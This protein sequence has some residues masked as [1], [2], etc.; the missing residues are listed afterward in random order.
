MLRRLES[1]DAR[2]RTVDFRP[3]F[4]LLVAD[5]TTRSSDTDTRNS[6]GKS[7]LIELIHFL[8][9][10]SVEKD[11]LVSKIELRDATF[12]LHLDWPSLP[13]PLAVS[14]TAAQPSS[15]V[16]SENVIGDTG[17]LFASVDGP[18]VTSM[19]QWHEAIERDLFGLRGEHPGVSGRSMLSFLIR[20]V[21][22]NA[23]NEAA[24]TFPR[25]AAFEGATNLAYLLG[26][27][28]QLAGRY[29]DLA[30]RENARKKLRQATA[31]PIL[32]RV[33]GRV[34]ELRA[35]ITVKERE[36]AELRRQ[37]D[38]FSVVPGFER[39]QSEAD[40]IAQRLRGSR[41][42]D[43]ADRRNL[44]DIKLALEQVSEPEP[45]YLGAIMSELDEL[46]GE[47]LRRRFDEVSAFH[48]SVVRNRRRFLRSEADETQARLDRRAAERSQLGARQAQILTQLQNG[49]ALGS[50]TEL[51]STYGRESAAL[52]AL[53]ARFAAAETLESSRTIIA[54]QKAQLQA[55]LTQDLN[56]RRPQVDAAVLMFS[57]FANALYSDNK[58][59]YL[60]FAADGTSLGINPRI[61]SD[62]GRG[63]GNM[64]IF[65][66]DLTVAVLA[67]R[68]GR[69][70]DFLVHDS[71]LFDGVDERQVFRAMRLA[72]R[73]VEE[74]GMQYLV[75]IN[76][77]D[78]DKAMGTS[79]GENA[80]QSLAE[81]IIEPRLTDADESGGLF[82]F[83]FT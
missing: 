50:L 37:I 73:V 34:A 36:V 38:N 14:R 60:E 31:D 43:A 27:D 75:T 41:T 44:Q 21:R 46:V 71:H 18:I 45:V 42:Q 5:R 33:V 40:D 81:C 52:E 39:L 65:C 24:R 22:S 67:H 66:F 79:V 55:E 15:V 30:A 76:S 10:S 48:A 35:Q 13:S 63:V 54:S 57:D 58:N 16:L 80:R 47:R 32:G 68:A 51:Q 7:S 74:E 77:D 56:D 29:R 62:A 59:A 2:F 25:Q 17:D 23:F 12:T 19:P 53:R 61:D 3:N 11:S 28:W 64:V 9:G 1:T 20:R 69:A 8:L 26:L 83:S 78:L 70:P 72:K 6:V 82:G 49:G 4:N